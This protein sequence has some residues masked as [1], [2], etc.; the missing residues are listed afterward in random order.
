[1]SRGTRAVSQPE[2]GLC[3]RLSAQVRRITQDN[4][5]VF[6]GPGTNTYLVGTDPVWV[7]DPG[8][9]DEAHFE[10]LVTEVADARVLGI[11]A[12]HS[13][14]D[15]W[16]LA[17]RLAER[18]ATLTL[19]FE[20]RAGFARQ[21][22]LADGEILDEGGLRLEAIHTPGH[23]SD[24]L[25]FL[26]SQA[27]T[28]FSGD[29]VMGW[30]TSVIAPP[31]GNLNDYMSSLDKLER[32]SY[33][34]MYPAHGLPIENP[35]RRIEALRRHRQLRT[36]PVLEALRTGPRRIP[37]LV[38]RIYV[39]LDPRLHTAAQWSLSAHL[40]ALVDAGQVRVAEAAEDALQAQYALAAG[41]PESR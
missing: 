40:L 23:A 16:P 5:G 3:V 1:M 30:S 26:F 32:Y 22:L 37:D 24:H 27:Q 4:P 29:H 25:C 15:H 8:P 34:C 33:R 19:G 38:D 7:L 21:R 35:G 36:H 9:D 18:F 6:T 2:V 12:T 17:P 13:H 14:A 41:E 10:R 28:L 11:I 39:G 31:G 20:A